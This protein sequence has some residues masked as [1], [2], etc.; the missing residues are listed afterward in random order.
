M[1]PTPPA[2][3]EPDVADVRHLVERFIASPLRERLAAAR[4]ARRELPFAFTLDVAGEELLVNGVLDVHAVEEGGALIVD[5]K[6]DRLDGRD[7][8]RVVDEEYATQRIVYAL[9]GLRAGA[10]TVEVAY[11]FL[12]R[13]DEPA[14]SIFEP[15]DVPVLEGRLLDLAGDLLAGRFEPTSAPHRG[16]CQFCAGQPALC[17]WEPERTLAAQPP[18]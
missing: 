3:L 12:D 13:P 6:S 1:E 11:C 4:I 18:A 7:P 2:P 10:P 17:S 5:Y 9:A 8:E 16:L 14:T 15:A